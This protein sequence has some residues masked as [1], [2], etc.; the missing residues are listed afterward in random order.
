MDSVSSRRCVDAYIARAA[1]AHHSINC[2]TEGA[3]YITAVYNLWLQSRA[4]VL[5]DEARK[6]AETLD[7]DFANTKMLKGPLHGV[8][9]SF[10][11]QCS[12]AGIFLY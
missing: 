2:L 1:F 4:A 6:E 7:E 8:P 11:D 10:K 5:F 12:F 9:F 3:W